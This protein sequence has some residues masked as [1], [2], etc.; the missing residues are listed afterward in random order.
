MPQVL[1]QVLEQLSE[2]SR[3]YLESHHRVAIC[4]PNRLAFTFREK[5]T[6]GKAFC[7]RPDQVAKLEKALALVTG[8]TVRVQFDLEQDLPEEIG[9]ASE[10][11]PRTRAPREILQEKAQHPLVRRAVELFDARPL[12][13]D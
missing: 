13:V 5:Y 3:V 11:R 4:A 12:R 10:E 2:L 6:S 1:S 7:E 9:A 8:E